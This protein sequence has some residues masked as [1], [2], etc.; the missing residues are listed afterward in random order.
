[1]EESLGMLRIR[2]RQ[3][4]DRNFAID[5]MVRITTPLGTFAF[6]AYLS[7]SMLLKWMAG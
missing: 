3:N 7:N 4:L 1:M 6:L 5:P 2:R